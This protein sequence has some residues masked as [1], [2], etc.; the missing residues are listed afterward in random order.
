MGA[1]FEFAGAS[2][3]HNRLIEI[4]PDGTLDT[5]FNPSI[6][7][8]V[9]ALAVSPDGDTLYV[10]GTFT[11]VNGSTAASRLVAFDTTTGLLT[12]FNPGVNSN[13]AALAL[14]PDGS[15]LYAAGI[16]T[17]VNGSTAE[18]RIAA[19]NTS[20]GVATA[21]NPNLNDNVNAIALS[22]DGTTVY[23]AGQFTTVNG[24][25]A[26]NRLAAFNST[27]GV[28]TGFNP[29][30]N[31]TIAGR[32]RQRRVRRVGVRGGGWTDPEHDLLLPRRGDERLRDIRRFGH[33]RDHGAG[34]STGR[35]DRRSVRRDADWR[36]A[37]GDGRRASENRRRSPSSSA[38]RRA[39]AP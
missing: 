14:T 2:T 12:A 5:S 37:D 6:N 36:D 16:F 19:F 38:R 30:V 23:A 32:A 9:A 10:G 35:H 18:N 28:A 22:P 34:R 39:S 11:S 25:V 3:I 13:V 21:F 1:R 29:N 7:N 15:T 31:N 17:M 24:G 8:T 33:Q 20:T 4:N 27:T 26:E